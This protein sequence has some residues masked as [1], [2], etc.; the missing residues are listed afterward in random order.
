MGMI[1]FK[2]FLVVELGSDGLEG[3]ELRIGN[4]FF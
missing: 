3:R 4:K 2:R 1:R